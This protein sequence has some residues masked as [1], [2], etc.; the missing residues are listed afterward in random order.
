METHQRAL[1]GHRTAGSPRG[2]GPGFLE[3]CLGVSMKTCPRAQASMT[4]R[5]CMHGGTRELSQLTCWLRLSGSAGGASASAHSG[6]GCVPGGRACPCLRGSLSHG[7]PGGCRTAAQ[8]HPTPT[9]ASPVGLLLTLHGSAPA[10]A[11]AM[12]G[13]LSARPWSGLRKSQGGKPLASPRARP[14]DP[15]KTCLPGTTA[16]AVPS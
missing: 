4:R 14:R 1:S 16:R 9:T 2:A 7:L 6:D 10:R 11:S 13:P 5:A 12:E 3:D 15:A 8:A